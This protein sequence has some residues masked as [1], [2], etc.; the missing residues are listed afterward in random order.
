MVVIDEVASA[1]Y[2]YGN[3]NNSCRI[4]FYFVELLSRRFFFPK[5]PKLR[6]K[7]PNVKVSDYCVI[8]IPIYFYFVD[9]LLRRFILLQIKFLIVLIAKPPVKPIER[10]I[11]PHFLLV[12]LRLLN[13][14]QPWLQH[15]R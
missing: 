11:G 2:H 3:A 15:D 10:E 12:C 13:Q 4:S 1:N 14:Q 5:I 8:V 6:E 7:H 9:L